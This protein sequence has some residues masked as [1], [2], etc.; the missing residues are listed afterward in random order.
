MLGDPEVRLIEEERIH[1]GKWTRT[2][3]GSPIDDSVG[4][5]RGRKK[6][7]D[8]VDDEEEEEEYIEDHR[9][10]PLLDESLAGF[11]EDDELKIFILCPALASGY[12]NA[13]PTGIG[14]PR[15]A[16]LQAHV[17]TLPFSC[18]LLV[19]SGSCLGR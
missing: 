5:P 1:R 9:L 14:D 6:K 10:P 13:P 3:G 16:R 11:D 18:A 15:A 7:T 2:D 17:D 19:R 4:H 8:S 12:S